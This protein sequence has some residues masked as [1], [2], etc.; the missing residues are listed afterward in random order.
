MNQDRFSDALVK[1]AKSPALSSGVLEEASIMISREGCQALG[2]HRVGLWR[3]SDGKTNLERSICY[4]AYTKEQIA[5]KDVDI[6]GCKDY[7]CA[8]ETE[9]HVII[10]DASLPNPISSIITEFGDDLCSIIDTPIRVGG[11]LYGVLGIE[12]DRCEEYPHYREWTEQE[13]SFASS[14]A[15]FMSIA[16]MMRDIKHRDALL[17]AVNNATVML[18][19]GS[20]S[21]DLEAPL[22]LSMEI[23][24]SAID[25]DSVHIWKNEKLDGQEHRV[26]KYSWFS[27]LGAKNTEAFAGLKF[28]NN[29]NLKSQPGMIAEGKISGPVSR[30]TQKAKALLKGFDVKSIAI[31]PIILDDEYWGFFTVDDC[32]NEREFTDEDINILR[33][34]SIILA[35]AINRHDIVAKR[36]QELAMQTSTLTTLFDTL[37]DLIFYKDINLKYIDV[38]KAFLDFFG[39]TKQQVIGKRSVEAVGL[40]EKLG[41]FFSER[42]RA[43]IEQRQTVVSEAELPGADGINRLYETSRIPIMVSGEA[44]GLVGISHDIAKLRE[45][46]RLA[47]KKYEYARYLNTALADIT[48]SPTIS[49][50]VLK[51]AADFIAREGCL[52]LDAHHIGIWAMAEGEESL[53]CITYYTAE[54]DSY[55]IEEDFDLRF[56]SKYSSLLHTERFI[57]M[58]NPDIIQVLIPSVLDYDAELCAFIEAPVRIDAK[59]YGAISVEQK[60]CE[61]YPKER[62]WTPEEQSFVSSLADLTALA[63]SGFERRKAREEA[64]HANK[65]K[66]TFFAKM[67]HEIRTPMNAIIGMAELALR[68]EMSDVVRDQILTVKQAGVNLL[69]IINDILDVSRIE[70]GGLQLRLAEYAMSS[71]VNDVVSIIRIKAF[72]SQLRFAVNLDSNIPNMLYGDET[73]LRQVLINILGNSVKYT[74]KGFLSLTVSAKQLSEAKINLVFEIRDSGKGMK[75][76]DIGKLFMD[77]SQIDIESNTGIEGVGLG[78]AI[79]YNIISIMEGGIEVESE[80]GQGS[81]FTI[82]IPQTIIKNEKLA[83]I[84][85]PDD[86]FVLI[87]ERR[88][89]YAE[90]IAKTVENLGVKFEAVGSDKQLHTALLSKSFS[91]LLVSH[92]LFSR[93]RDIILKTCGNAKIVLLTEFGESVPPG[94]WDTLAMPVHALSVANLINGEAESYTYSVGGKSPLRFTAPEANVLVVDDINTN[95]KVASGLLLPYNMT[96]D[97]CDSGIKA[98]EAMTEK[99]YDIVFMDH[100][101]PGMDG[102]E[103]TIRIRELGKENPNCSDVPIIALTANAV[104]GMRETF[105]QNGFNDFMSKPIDTVRLNAVLEKWLPKEKRLRNISLRIKKGS[106][107]KQE[108][109]LSIS[110]IDV[111]RGIEHSGG[112]I[113]LYI[114]TLSIF[115][116]DLNERKA[117]IKRSLEAGNIPLY[118]THVHAIKSASANVGAA[119]VSAAAAA[120]ED[121]GVRQDMTYISENS[122]SF[123]AMIEDLGKK[124]TEALTADGSGTDESW[125]IFALEEF[126]SNLSSLKVALDVMDIDEMNKT[127]DSLL[128]SAN[129]GY[130]LDKVRELSKHIL[131]VQYDEAI[132]IIDKLL[133][134]GL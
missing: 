25:V 84:E 75:K 40:P 130:I 86:K 102:M 83:K 68:E 27:E 46:Q 47:T 94:D 134:T 37:P 30:M 51:E 28:S 106:P 127:L 54:T 15:D 10:S 39:R 103:T 17:Q 118:V 23:I 71:L 52:A 16:I 59:L 69:S 5:V 100:R 90:S 74:K 131:L 96:V 125:D 18:L 132:E 99:R 115:C 113:E 41:V 128:L 89:I 77:Y 105:L 107:A 93:N 120:L 24:G 78:L 80:Y 31:I 34:V 81:V 13:Q 45:E 32:R 33:S 20:E 61:K 133:Q 109:A 21:E 67:S 82:T 62:E 111:S 104:A 119:K 79:S 95:L 42:D 123:L 11:V 26:C 60:V 63:L 48:K 66:S 87:Y 64:E 19:T 70:S 53:Q 49:S 6:S 110:E 1:I 129:E 65:T 9:R 44:V 91:M 122:D 3:L 58:N 72:D 7:V 14:L 116:E 35:S 38:N 124:I 57:L 126:K 88:E 12:Q 117:E 50:G 2:T 43:A 56:C 36:T 98:I 108:T 97:L 29:D 4:D 22:K 92:I 85:N 112:T 114:E 8:L 55:E 76:E 73:R 121:A 101:M